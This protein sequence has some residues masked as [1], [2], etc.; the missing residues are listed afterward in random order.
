[1]ITLRDDIDNRIYFAMRGGLFGGITGLGLGAYFC[2]Q[3]TQTNQ[4]TDDNDEPK[5][6]AL[7]A[8]DMASVLILITIT[9]ICIG[10]TVLAIASPV[11]TCATE[12]LS[13]RKERSNSLTDEHLL[14]DNNDILGES[15]RGNLQVSI[16]R[17]RSHSFF[18]AP[19]ALSP[20]SE[21]AREGSE[22]SV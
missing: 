3:I 22:C 12:K 6:K 8:A 4:D 18:E 11:L 19:E 1:M 9:G 16:P 20:V 21:D 14:E 13:P 2:Y 17:R 7:S 10:G 5:E 15:S